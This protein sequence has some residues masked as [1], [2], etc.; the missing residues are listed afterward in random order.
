MRHIGTCCTLL[1]SGLT[2]LTLSSCSS[3]MQN[4]DTYAQ[5]QSTS[6]VNVDGRLP[7]H[8]VTS[9][10]EVVVDPS[11]H[12][13]GAYD[14]SGN[15]I[16][17]GLASAGSSY[18]GDLHRPC[19]TAVGDF[20]IQSLGDADCK[21]HEFPLPNGGAPMPYCMY[22]NTGMALHGVP[23]PEVQDANIS[24]GCVRMHVADAEWLRYNFADVG[25]RVVVKPY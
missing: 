2:A 7:Q 14:S 15:L 3:T 16:R 10:K 21:S 6:N 8:I 9:E 20:R 4:N 17:T 22:F 12:V 1:L 13:W 19:H 11:Q 24:H 18:C 25:T 5:N 23:D